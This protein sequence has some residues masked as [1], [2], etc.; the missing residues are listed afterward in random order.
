M[1]KQSRPNFYDLSGIFQNHNATIYSDFCHLSEEGNAIVAE[2]VFR[3]IS[4]S[5]LPR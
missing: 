3:A 4:E 2:G 5:G 1:K